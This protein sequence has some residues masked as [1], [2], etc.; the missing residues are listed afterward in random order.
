METRGLFI[1]YFRKDFTRKSQ[2]FLSDIEKGNEWDGG[3]KQVMVE[4]A[5]LVGYAED[6]ETG[7]S[8]DGGD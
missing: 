7:G 4:C 1:L 5:Q 3:N 8:K 6:A 2:G